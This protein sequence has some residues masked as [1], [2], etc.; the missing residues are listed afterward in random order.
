MHRRSVV[1]LVAFAL[2]AG[3]CSGGDGKK[4]DATSKRTTTTAERSVATTT[5]GSKVDSATATTTKGGS[6][7][8]TKRGTATT[9]ASAAPTTDPNAV[10]APA[11]TGTYDYAQSG[12]TST[13]GPVPPE[14][15]LT[16]SGSGPAQ[17]FDRRFDGSS[18][19]DFSLS[20]VFRGDGPFITR[21]VVSQ[22]GVPITCNFGAPVPAPPWPPT[23]GRTFSGHATCS[24]GL[25]A[26][27][28]G[29]ITGRVTDTVGSAR[30]EAVVVNST[31]HVYGN[32]VDINVT[33]TQH[34]APSLRVPTY[35]HEV[36]NGT[37]P[38]V[39]AITG[40]VTSRLKSV[41]PR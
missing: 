37:A 3:A 32:G 21:I 23:T 31:L 13:D 10:P 25:Q 4:V 16:V 8:T 30:V 24:N 28:N 11:A 38:F 18:N 15:T 12:Q 20:Y 35:S 2:V 1:F 22:E 14:G 27:F 36:V 17:T 26:D 40:D 39:G 6:A 33:D 9:A 7:T 5:P 29:S 19:P 41:N 34:W